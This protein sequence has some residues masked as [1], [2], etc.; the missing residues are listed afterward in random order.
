MLTKSTSFSNCYFFTSLTISVFLHFPTFF[1]FI[2]PGFNVFPGL[3]FDSYQF[4]HF[5]H[6]LRCFT[7]LNIVQRFIL[8][9]IVSRSFSRFVTFITSFFFIAFQHFITNVNYNILVFIKFNKRFL[10][11]ILFSF[12]DLKVSQPIITVS[13]VL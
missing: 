9:S 8:S 10:I 12:R 5:L 11:Y 4:S 6:S 1:F 3:V 2:Y 13:Y 7:F